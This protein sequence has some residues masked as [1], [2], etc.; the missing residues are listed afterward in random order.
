MLVAVTVLGGCGGSDDADEPP[1]VPDDER[2]VLRTI[3]ALQSASRQG[4]ARRICREIFSKTLASSIRDASHQSCEAE[5]RETFVGRDTRIAVQ[6][7]IR[8]NGARARAT[9]RERSGETSTV[10]LVRQ[11]GRWRIERIAPVGS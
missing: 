9:V 11:G 7:G 10:V 1:A 6:R 8:I 4:D 2:A 5:I 3:D